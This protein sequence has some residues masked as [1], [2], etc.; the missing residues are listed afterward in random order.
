[1]LSGSTVYDGTGFRLQIGTCGDDSGSDYTMLGYDHGS[2]YTFTLQNASYVG[3]RIYIATSATGKEID[4]VMP[5][6]LRR[7]DMS[8]DFEPFG[9]KIPLTVTS[10]T[11][12]KDTV[13]PIGDTKL[14]AED[15]IDYKS[16]KI[17]KSGGTEITIDLPAIETFKG[18][19]TLDSTETLGEVTIKGKIKSQS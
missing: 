13:V 17:H 18:T 11:Q 1:M 9:Y 2:G 19:N 16:G 3:V 10:G 15:Y 8:P 12:T 14:M 7:A 4:A 5:I 6:M